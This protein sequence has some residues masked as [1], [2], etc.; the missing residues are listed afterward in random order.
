MAVATYTVDTHIISS[1]PTTNFASA[2]PLNLQWV[3]TPST[4]RILANVL[5]NP[6]PEVSSAI[7]TLT[8]ASISSSGQTALAHILRFGISAFAPTLCTWDDWTTGQA[9]PGG[10]GGYG[11]VNPSVSAVTFS[12]PTGSVGTQVNVNITSLW[13]QAASEGYS[14]FPLILRFQ[15]ESSSS[16]TAFIQGNGDTTPMFIT[17]TPL[18]LPPGTEG[19]FG[20]RFQE[21][22]GRIDG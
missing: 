18:D 17:Y 13:N 19:S 14:W 3:S 9:W 6:V 21:L 12:P 20:G 4:T 1:D 10:G 2:N 22:K 7:L 11:D 15:T 5:I 16:R 8:N